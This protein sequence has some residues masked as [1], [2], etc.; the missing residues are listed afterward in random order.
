[1]P[2]SATAYPFLTES[3]SDEYLGSLGH[4]RVVSEL[5][6]GGMGFVF[7]AEDVKLKRSVALKVMNQKISEVAGSRKRFISEAR[8]M[9]AVHHDNVA[10]IFEVGESK[11]TPFMA[12]EM[13]QGETLEAFNRRKERLDYDTI[14]DYA[15]DIV[16]G[17]AAAHVRGIVH[18]DIKPANIWIE[19][20][21]NRIKI[22][23]F[24]LALA[25]TPVDHLAGR[26]S[27]VGTPGYLSPEQARS[28]P[29]D[30]R[31]DL[32]SLGV[33]L[34]ELCTGRLPIQSKSVHQQL[35]SIL[36]HKPTPI[37]EVNPDV[38]KPLCDMIHKLL[39]KEP[40]S[41]YQSAKVLEA[42]LKEVKEACHKQSEVAQAINRL[43]EGLNQVATASGATPVH[44]SVLEDTGFSG[45]DELPAPTMDPLSI[46]PG[47]LGQPGSISGVY[48]AAP[49]MPPASRKPSPSQKAPAA[50]WQQYMPLIVIAC[51]AIIALP[52]MTFF[53]TGITSDKENY[54]IINPD[55]RP[56]GQTPDSSPP[57]NQI[58]G[59]GSSTPTKKPTQK[60]PAQKNPA[61]KKQQT[62]KSA[63][64]S[65]PNNKRIKPNPES[66]KPDAPPSNATARP[67]S[68]R[69]NSGKDSLASVDL[70]T[71]KI[72][73]KPVIAEKP[74]MTSE[75]DPPKPTGTKSVDIGPMQQ[76]TVRT[77]EGRGADA[78][79]QDNV[80]DSMGLRPSIGIRSRDGKEINHT[81]VRFDLTES[82]IDAKE[83]HDA[84]LV[85]N[86]FGGRTP[87]GAEIR[88]I[89]I[90]DAGM[91]PEDRIQWRLSPSN[92]QSPKPL[93]RFPVVARVTVTE[94]SSVDE[95]GRIVLSDPKLGEFVR[96]QTETVTLAIAGHWNGR[97]LRFAAREKSIE[98]APAL[99]LDVP[100]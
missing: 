72:A 76:M 82:G 44:S 38:P 84:R 56:P 16:R 86:L 65:K 93:D 25:S 62:A 98:L 78:M 94:S 2:D 75:T 1:M 15:T 52:L 12:M 34:Y 6:R 54:V 89:G 7:K 73:S 45:I 10:T 91:W 58:P 22:L 57:K 20:K 97:L 70:E 46:P 19:A 23:D 42:T 85:L 32:Y 88:V 92:P 37:Q 59:A 31:S 51:A 5:G 24:G 49:A 99:E 47:P 60:N 63:A 9:A 21:S 27:V 77:S 28:D 3:T 43:Q 36:A 29:L 35:I 66:S 81:Y 87:I 95:T 67:G 18:R 48:A 41:R 50:S 96:S 69:P 53:F 39:R 79:V 14:I 71:E 40:R 8:A 74:A 83:I 90:E 4:Y 13:L 11:G 64:T 55:G 61:Q 68:S 100:K 80:N 26:G 33:V 30:D 17:L